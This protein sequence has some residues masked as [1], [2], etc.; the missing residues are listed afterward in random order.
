MAKKTQLNEMISLINRMDKPQSGWATLLQEAMKSATQ[1]IAPDAMTFLSKN[2]IKEGDL[3]CLGY[4]QLYSIPGQIPSDDLYN[5]MTGMGSEIDNPRALSNFNAYMDK[6]Q[7]TEWDNPTG[8][9]KPGAGKTLKTKLYSHVIKVSRYIMHWQGEEGYQR[10]QARKSQAMADIT[11][12]WPQE[13]KDEVGYKESEPETGEFSKT[14]HFYMEP[15]KQFGVATYGSKV[16]DAEGN[17]TMTPIKGSYYNSPDDMNSGQEYDNFAIRN[18][19]SRPED[20]LESVYFGV[21]ENG[22]IDPIPNRLGKF[23]QGTTSSH[24]RVDA[25]GDPDKEA[26]FKS[27]Y[28]YLDNEDFLQKTFLLSNVAYLCMSAIDMSSG[29]KSSKFWVNENPLFL[30]KKTVNKQDIK[31]LRLIN[32]EELKQA[33]TMFAKKEA[34][35]LE[36]Y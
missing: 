33:L 15:H 28:D 24:R 9:A 4:I 23:L 6:A 34:D 29:A 5:Q 19:L 35:N 3:C 16:R 36:L 26:A 1:V 31:Y 2:L 20:N 14:G 10:A 11:K 32:K 7:N 27:Y 22:D 25:G 30:L 21:Y 8:R 18:R 12:T 17:V 13:W